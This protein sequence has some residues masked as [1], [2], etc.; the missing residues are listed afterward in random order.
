MVQAQWWSGVE[1][2]WG[3]LQ[4]M[5][6]VVLQEHVVP[7]VP[8]IGENFLLMHDNTRLHK[9]PCVSYLTMA[10]PACSPDINPIEHVWDM[11]AALVVIWDNLPRDVI[12]NVIRS[13]MR[14]MTAVTILKMFILYRDF[15]LL[16]SCPLK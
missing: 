7:F 11:L 4:H 5:L 14:R 12:D 3:H 2:A 9:A 6:R 15:L 16:T 1:Y 8:H 10:W 13:M